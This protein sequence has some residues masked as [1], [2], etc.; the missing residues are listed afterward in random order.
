VRVDLST[1]A[2]KDFRGYRSR[3]EQRSLDGALSLL[4]RDPF[5]G[6]PKVGSLEGY[7]TVDFRTPGCQHRLAYYIDW[8]AR[9]CVVV[10]I[11]RRE[12]FYERLTQ[13]LGKT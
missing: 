8:E 12:K 9:V 13:R 6:N 2:Q 3:Q 1:A 4:Q 5:A 11:G 10:A 7:R